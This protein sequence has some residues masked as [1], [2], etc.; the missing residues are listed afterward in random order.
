MSEVGPSRENHKRGRDRS[1]DSS[2][3]SKKPNNSRNGS[4]RKKR[5]EFI[6]LPVT[7][8]EGYD[9]RGEHRQGDAEV[10]VVANFF[11]VESK[12]IS[13]TK[14]RVD[15]D[16]ECE[17]PG[18]RRALMWQQKI[19]LGRFVYDDANEVCLLRPLAESPLEL[20]SQS[21]EGVD[22]K[23]KLRQTVTVHFTEA[24]YLQVLNLILRN[25][26]RGLNLQLVGRNFYDA[27]PE[28]VVS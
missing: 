3:R 15:F 27:D 4:G 14:Y 13:V 17:I 10:N 19:Q 25:G 21:R 18:L 5:E 1:E 6:D 26:M 12:K 2:D 24:A 11:R 23:I 28:V 20:Q 16:P 7:R 9:K 8:E 22:Y